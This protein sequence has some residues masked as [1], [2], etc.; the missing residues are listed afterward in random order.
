MNQSKNPEYQAGRVDMAVEQC[1]VLVITCSFAFIPTLFMQGR[2]S[3][4]NQV[5][6]WRKKTVSK[7]VERTQWMC[8]IRPFPDMKFF[9]HWLHLKSW[10]YNA[11]CI[12]LICNLNP[13]PDMKLSY[14]VIQLIDWSTIFCFA[15]VWLQNGLSVDKSYALYQ[16]C[17]LCI[18]MCTHIA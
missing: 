2:R 14:E 18:A 10:L 13:F 12:L 3:W 8:N 11:K 4:G 17:V 6:K 9:S 7:L 16:Q 5:T 1:E 15:D